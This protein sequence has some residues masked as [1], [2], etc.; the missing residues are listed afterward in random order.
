MPSH[1]LP[2]G[3][4]EV[5]QSRMGLGEH[6]SELRTRLIRSV[7]VML[8]A[9]CV[10]YAYRDSVLQVIQGPQQKAAVMLR[11]E[12]ADRMQTEFSDRT[13]NGADTSPASEFTA[14]VNGVFEEGW[15]ETWVLQSTAGPATKMWIFQSDGGFFL[16]MRVCFWL[17]LFLAGP[18][19]IWEAWGFIATGLYAAEKRMAYAYFP[20]SMILFFGGVL[21]GYFVMIP[22]ALYFLNLDSLGLEGFEVQMGVDYY[23][24]FLKGLSL[25]L[26][27]VFQLPVIMVA[28][29]RL[30]LVDPKDFSKFRKHTLVAALVVGALLTPPDPITQ[31]LMAGPVILL[32][33][34]GLRVSYLVWKEPRV[35]LDDK[36]GSD[37]PAHA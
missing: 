9:F 19:L 16:K 3:S 18:F 2:D 6:L 14:E 22:Y 10:L 5:E 28:L 1:Q 29:S 27:F 34:L 20:V 17:A 21:F 7:G 11:A 31:L 37:G 24:G 30:G 35:S 13:K 36:E 25:A 33:E 15:P 8:L 32:Y 12:Y 26:G 23:L 4:D